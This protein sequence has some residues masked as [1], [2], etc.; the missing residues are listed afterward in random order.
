ML[1]K[2]KKPATKQNSTTNKTYNDED[3]RK[4]QGPI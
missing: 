1:K 4:T 2:K 3:T